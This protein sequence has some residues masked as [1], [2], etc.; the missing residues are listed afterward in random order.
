[1]GIGGR[2]RWGLV[3]V[4]GGIAGGVGGV[5]TT[6]GLITRMMGRVRG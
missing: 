1:M 6:M 4:D 5:L 2:D 3:G